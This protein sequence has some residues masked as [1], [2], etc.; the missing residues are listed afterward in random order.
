MELCRW[1]EPLGR[2]VEVS[3]GGVSWGDEM[4]S[5]RSGMKRINSICSMKSSTYRSNLRP[6]CRKPHSTSS[7]AVIL[8]GPFICHNVVWREGCRRPGVSTFYTACDFKQEYQIWTRLTIEH[9][10]TFHSSKNGNHLMTSA[11]G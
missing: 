9:F 8:L 1:S 10:F 7:A 2:Y 3:Q 11:Y 6:A 4:P 5:S